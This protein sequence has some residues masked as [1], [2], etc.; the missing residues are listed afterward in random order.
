MVPVLFWR[1]VKKEKI[2]RMV[3]AE[4]SSFRTRWMISYPVKEECT[5]S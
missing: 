1:E 5:A 3:Q 4:A 2:F